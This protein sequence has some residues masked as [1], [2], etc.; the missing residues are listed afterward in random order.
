M[1]LKFNSFSKKQMIALSWWCK[2]STYKNKDA[3]ICDGAIRSG[4]TVC[5]SISFF[6]WAFYSFNNSFFAI[7]GKTIRSL[8]RNIINIIIPTLNDLGFK[9]YEKISENF[10]DITYM[11]KTNKFYLF[12]GKDESSA[13]LIQGI[14]LA[15]ILFDEVALMPQSFVEQAIARCSVEGSKFWFNCNPEY[16]GH[17]FYR[18]WIQEYKKKNALYLHFKMEDNPSLMPHMIK[19]YKTLY[20]GTFYDRF[21]EGKWI[22]AQGIVYP[23]MSDLEKFVPVPKCDFDKYIISCDYGTVNPSSFGLWGLHNK[24]WYRIKEYY[25]DSRKLGIQRTD[26]EHY[27]ALLD[28]GNKIKIDSVVIDPSA[29]SFITLIKRYGKFQVI[30]AKNNVIDGIREVST[31]LKKEEIKIC[32]ICQDSI[33]EFSLYRWDSSGNKDSPVKE[34]D[35]AMDDIRYFVSTILM[36]DNTNF[37]VVAARR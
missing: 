7:C 12:G 18:E 34:N 32:D 4:K 17:W 28:L 21:I 14:T 10:I 37:I 22:A 35:H 19:R 23:E 31:L 9:C 3:L 2:E 11:G 13:S 30:K 24:V 26:E 27:Q 36:Q 5:M 8:K 15:G 16:P 20:R 6:A 25:Y 29:A 33:R 1:Y